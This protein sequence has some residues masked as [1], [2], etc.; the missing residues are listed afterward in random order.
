MP[1]LFGLETRTV[2]QRF[3]HSD[4]CGLP[5]GSFWGLCRR[6][7]SQ[8]ITMRNRRLRGELRGTSGVDLR[9]GGCGLSD[10]NGQMDCHGVPTGS[11]LDVQYSFTKMWTMPAL[12]FL[13]MP[14]VPL[15]H[16]CQSPDGVDK[17]PYREVV[18]TR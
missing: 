3:E 15:S 2:L 8:G 1:G 7:S 11:S 10:R 6:G 9:P 18:T 5:P 17:M 14:E 13:P 12:P 16:V 4:A